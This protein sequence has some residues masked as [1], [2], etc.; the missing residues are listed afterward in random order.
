MAAHSGD[1]WIL[2]VSHA[3]SMVV[4]IHTH[5]HVEIPLHTR[6]HMHNKFRVKCERDMDRWNE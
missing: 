3:H 4:N 2:F 6:T 5:I 1:S